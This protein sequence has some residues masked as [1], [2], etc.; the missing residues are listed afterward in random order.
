MDRE[1]RVRELMVAKSR[2]Q[3]PTWLAIFAMVLVRVARCSNFRRVRSL[4]QCLL[5]TALL[6][7]LIS[8]A[9]AAE[10]V[11]LVIGNDAYTALPRLQK[12][13]NDS[14]AIADALKAIGFNVFEGTDLTRRQTSRKLADFLA[15]IDPGD[16]VFVFFSGHGVAFG[17][18]NFLIPTDMPRPRTGQESLVRDEAFALSDLIARVRARK[19]GASFFVVD[20]CRDNPFRAIG[21]KSIGYS[22]GLTR[23]TAPTGVF[24]LYSAGI[25]QQALDRMSNDDPNP[26]SVFTRKL[27]PL[28]KTPGLSHVRLAKRVQ[29]QVSALAARIE[30][31]QEPAY[32]DQ[33]IGEVTLVPGESCAGALDDWDWVRDAQSAGALKRFIARYPGCPQAELAEQRLSALSEDEETDVAVGVFPEEP[34]TTP[35]PGQE[36]C[37]GVEVDLAS[38][39]TKCIK[40]GSGEPFK[41]CAECP[42][43]VVVPAGSFMMG[44]PK[45]EEGR[46]DDEGPQHEVAIPQPFAVGKFEVTWDEWEACVAAGG[47]DGE[48]VEDAGGDNGWGKGNRP[49]INVSWDDA[50]AY[51]KWLSEKTGKR[52]RLLSEAEW[53]YAARAGT[54]GPFSFEGPITTDKANY[55]GDDSYAG[56][57]KGEDRGRTVPVDSF[58]PNPWGLYQVHG[59]VWEWVE[60]C[61]YESYADKPASLKASG[62][63]WTTGSCYSRFMRGGSSGFGPRELRAAGRVRLYRDSRSVSFGFRLARTLT[64]AATASTETRVLLYD[65]FRLEREAS[66]N[67]DQVNLRFGLRTVGSKSAGLS[68]NGKRVSMR[69]KDG[70]QI[71]HQG[72]TCELILLDTDQKVQRADFSLACL[73][74]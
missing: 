71:I 18:E 59:N 35:E 17:G 1:G 52:Y 37:D 29:E 25:G 13:V 72:V 12:A 49:V 16:Q 47:C 22:K 7:T 60:D 64:P 33:I 56:S 43:M 4:K 66:R 14:R 28:L 46:N 55:D 5:V 42:E 50:T 69:V 20:A 54:T 6:L 11:A 32:Y 58:Q 10:R 38:G 68:V 74:F 40:P 53:E 23:V 61:Y 9:H 27:L 63:A 8:P 39:G 26:N 34:E 44:S 2:R 31:R 45:D 67:F 48:G 65:R 62:E 51:A 41:D 19:P 30:H 36:H 21:V 70:K 24:V 57:P 3:L 15:A 73:R